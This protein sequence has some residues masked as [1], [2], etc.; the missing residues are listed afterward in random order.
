MD[1]YCVLYNPLSGNGQGEDGVKN[2]IGEVLKGDVKLFDLTKIQNLQ[3]FVNA[4]G[5]DEKIIIAGGDGTLNRF[6][7]AVDCDSEKREIY[8][9]SAGNG[10]DFLRDV[11][12]DKLTKID[13]YL[14]NLPEVTVNGKT[15]KFVNGVGFGIDGYCCEEGDRLKA[16][17]KKV[18]YTSIAIKGLLFKFKP[19]NAEVTVD[20]V[21]K[22]YKKTWIAPAML[23]RFYGGGM[24]PT[25]AQD[26]NSGKLS[27][28]V[29]YGKGKLKTLMAFP[30]IFSGEHVKKTKIVEVREGTVISVR[31]DKPCALQIDGET[32]TGVLEYTV[33]AACAQ[34]AADLSAA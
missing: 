21:T 12:G 20:G 16:A 9:F 27:V 28:C 15:Y 17:K 23:G 31:F 14:K 22:K 33:R 30:K 3:E 4:L 10:N 19:K 26:R 8:L 32:I 18:N 24:M 25:P 1:K 5:G 2:A 11:G 6:V 13:G 34:T 7:N 29:M